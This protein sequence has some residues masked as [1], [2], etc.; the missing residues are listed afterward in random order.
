MPSCT[1]DGCD[2]P[3][4]VR[5][6]GWCAMHYSRWQRHG[7][8]GPGAAHR[9]HAS[10]AREPRRCKF[11]GCTRTYMSKGLCASHNWQRNVG[12]ELTALSDRREAKPSDRNERGEKQCRTCL[13][14]LD[15]GR[16]GR[17]SSAPDGL[18]GHCRDCA[19]DS[20]RR[21]LYRMPRGRYAEMLDAQGGSCAICK[22]PSSDGRA[23]AID[24]DHFCCPDSSESCGRCVR[25]LLCAP[26]NQGLGSFRDSPE[27]LRAAAAYLE[28]HRAR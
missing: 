11:P 13:V 4:R 12:R 19:R 9:V 15:V 25:A 14:W 3:V 23:L 21:T 27:L 1:V 5:S 16:F 2:R 20:Q 17:L 26:C 18:Q 10:T 6:R 22:R 28:H 8:P 7:D 24:H